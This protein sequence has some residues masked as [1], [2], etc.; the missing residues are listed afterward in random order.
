M[1]LGSIDL[2]KLPTDPRHKQME[3]EKMVEINQT[4][5]NV[6]EKEN[7]NEM[8]NKVE[9]ENKNEMANKNEKENKNEMENIP[10]TGKT[11]FF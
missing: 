5:E 3:D 6:N 11:I 2:T 8:A 1:K 10:F 9:K 7:K 4:M